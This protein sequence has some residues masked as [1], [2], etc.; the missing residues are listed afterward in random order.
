MQNTP[1]SPRRARAH[2][3]AMTP[4]ETAL[5][6]VLRANRFQG[7]RFRRQHPF[8]PY[9]LDFYCDRVRL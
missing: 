6:R 2:R 7:L 3:Q 8:G 4:S 1:R 9:V 5:W